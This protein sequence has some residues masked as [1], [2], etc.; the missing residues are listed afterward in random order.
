MQ[1][2]RRA[3]EHGDDAQTHPQHGVDFAVAVFHPAD[4]HEGGGN[5]YRSGGKDTRKFESDKKQMTGKD[6][7][8]YIRISFRSNSSFIIIFYPEQVRRS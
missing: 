2:Q 6:R 5:G 3:A 7:I 8:D 1:Q 4:L